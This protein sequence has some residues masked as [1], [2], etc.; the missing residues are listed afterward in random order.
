MLKYEKYLKTNH[1]ISHNLDE[2][3]ENMFESNL[4]KI[5]QPYSNVELSHVSAMIKL[6]LDQVER[7]L[8]Q[9]VLDKKLHG[10]L[11]QGKG[12]LVIYDSADADANYSRA[13]EIIHNMGDA[14]EGLAQRTKRINTTKVLGDIPSETPSAD[15]KSE[16]M[17][18]KK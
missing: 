18:D 9:M 6:P 10:I 5:V 15:K 13:L 8:S 1:L 11:E 17:K 7:K 4:L 3:Y 12:H 2:L 16:E 14:V